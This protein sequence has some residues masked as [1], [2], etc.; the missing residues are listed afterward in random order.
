MTDVYQSLEPTD[1]D[2]LVKFI[3]TNSLTERRIAYQDIRARTALADFLTDRERQACKLKYAEG[4]SVVDVTISMGISESTLGSVIASARRKLT[5]L[6]PT[7]EA[8]DSSD[9]SLPE[10]A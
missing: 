2:N 4:M 10:A 5:A 9:E 8:A 7:E 3:T 1:Q 6:L